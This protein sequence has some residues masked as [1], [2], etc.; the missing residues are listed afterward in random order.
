MEMYLYVLVDHV[1]LLLPEYLSLSQ[2]IA[3][4]FILRSL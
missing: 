2:K 1:F 4:A 3:I